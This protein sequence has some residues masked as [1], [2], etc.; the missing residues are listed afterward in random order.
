MNVCSHCGWEVD[1]ECCWCGDGVKNHAYGDQGHSFVPM[2]CTCMYA[3][4]EQR[5][6]PNMALTASGE[7][8]K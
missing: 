2:G 7:G 4:A 1:L 6:N 8:A 3:D 5:K